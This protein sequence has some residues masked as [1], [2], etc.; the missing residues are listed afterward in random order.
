MCF[1]LHSP[2]VVP[3]PF[4]MT[5]KRRS[6]EPAEWT[7]GLVSQRAGVE[8]SWVCRFRRVCCCCCCCRCFLHAWA[9]HVTGIEGQDVWWVVEETN[10]YC[11]MIENPNIKFRLSTYFS[12]CTSWDQQPLIGALGLWYVKSRTPSFFP[13]LKACVSRYFFSERTENE[14]LICEGALFGSVWDN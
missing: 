5:R 3:A 2:E 14:C 11:Q 8:R 10:K 1:A 4:L 6:W 9:K 7:R 13:K 12:Q